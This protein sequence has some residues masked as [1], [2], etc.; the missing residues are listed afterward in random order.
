MKKWP[1]GGK[2]I[3]LL[4]ILAHADT[5]V[6]KVV[7]FT[8]CLNT[9]DFIESVLNTPQWE[10]SIPNLPMK[11]G[12]WGPWSKNSEYLCIVGGTTAVERGELI[13]SFNDSDI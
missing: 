8:Q 11:D 9:L 1:N 12:S 6:D 3:L 5:I 7:V 13:A 4:K 10:Q 2:I